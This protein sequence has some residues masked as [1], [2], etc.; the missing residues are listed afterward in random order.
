MAKNNDAMCAAHD[1]WQK[2]VFVLTGID[3][4]SEDDDVIQPVATH[5]QSIVWPLLHA[6]FRHFEH[7]ASRLQHSAQC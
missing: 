2:K 1:R 7:E 5:G 3:H 4:Q 6:I